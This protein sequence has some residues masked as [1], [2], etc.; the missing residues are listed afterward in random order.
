MWAGLLP[1][2][3]SIF[4]IEEKGITL[5]DWHDRF[6]FEVLPMQKANLLWKKYNVST[7]SQFSD[8]TEQQR[9]EIASGIPALSKILD[10]FL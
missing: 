4:Y 3:E 1:Y 8:L 5:D 7:V 2:H 9:K 6:L 10:T